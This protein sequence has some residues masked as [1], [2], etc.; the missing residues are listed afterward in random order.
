MF[1]LEYFFVFR[2][3]FRL[4][5]QKFTVLPAEGSRDTYFLETG[6]PARLPAQL[7]GPWGQKNR[8]RELVRK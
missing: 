1:S 6:D 5:I 7:A 3:I 2:F 4:Q 8:N